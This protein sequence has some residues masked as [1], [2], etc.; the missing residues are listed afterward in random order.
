MAAAATIT[1]SETTPLVVRGLTVFPDRLQY[2]KSRCN[3]R[4]IRRVGWYWSSETVNLV[5]TQKARLTIHVKG[6][7]DPIVIT[8]RTMYVAPRLV[9]AYNYIAQETFQARLL[10]YAEQL[11]EHGAFTF[12]GAT[13]YADGRILA[14]GNAFRLQDADIEPFKLSARQ[15]GLFSP[16]LRVDLTTDNDVVMS[17]LLFIMS[18]PRDPA[19]VKAT[20]GERRHAQQVADQF[21]VDVMSMLA[22]VSSADGR[23]SAEE[24]GVIKQ[25]ATEALRLSPERMTRAVAMFQTAAASAQPFEY[26]ARGFHQAHRLNQDLLRTVHDL[27]FAVASSDQVLSAEEELLLLEAEDIFGVHGTAFGAFR[28]QKRDDRRDATAQAEDDFLRIL[29]LGTGVNPS[30]IK[31]R[32]RRLVLQYHPDRVQHLGSH[33]CEEAE[34]KMTEINI[35]YDF[36]RKKYAM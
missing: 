16:R 6:L 3:F 9:T 31:A 4:D 29:G 30:E 18:N 26:F 13:F 10:A 14:N 17:L 19:H 32:Y 24:I 27:L 22:K 25:F 12:G 28:E 20:A 8:H 15:G 33:F 7:S 35:A 21:L 1:I 2:R 36:F 11:E 23:V 5:N 34:K